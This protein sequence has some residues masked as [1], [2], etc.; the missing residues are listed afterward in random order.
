VKRL[1]IVAFFALVAIVFGTLFPYLPRVRNPNENTRTYATMAVVEEHTFRVDEEVKRYAWTNDLARVPQPDGSSHLFAVK[2]PGNTYLAIPVYWALRGLAPV[3]HL[4]AQPPTARSSPDER[5]RWFTTTT[6]VLR[7]L[8]V[9]IP[10][11]LFLVWLERWLRST[12]RDVVLRIAAVAGAGLGTNYLAYSLMFVSHTLCGA[13]AF[14]AFGLTVRSWLEHAGPRYRSART[15]LAIGF[16][17]GGAVMFEY[18][19][20]PAAFVLAVFAACVHRRP[21]QLLALAAGGSV[22]VAGMMLYQWKSFGNPLTPGH[23]FVESAVFRAQHEKGLYGIELP[24]LGVLKQMAFSRAFGFFG[25]S[26]FMW[27]GLLSIPFGVF[28]GV[29]HRRGKVKLRVVIAL[30]WLIVF[31]AFI[32]VSGNQ[33]WHGGWSIGPRYWTVG[34]PFFAFAAVYALE[35]IAS[36]WPSLRPAARAVAAGMALASVVQTGLVSITYNT[37]PESITRPLA[38]ATLPLLRDGYVPH[39]LAELVGFT[40]TRFFYFVAGCLLI[41][42]LIPLAVRAG[43]STRVTVA[44]GVS[45]LAIAGLALVPAFSKPEP[46]EADEA[47]GGVRFLVDTWDPLGR[48]AIRD[49]RAEVAADKKHAPCPR[50]E[51]AHMERLVGMF[52]EAARDEAGLDASKCGGAMATVDAFLMKHAYLSGPGAPR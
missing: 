22:H 40:G 39:H 16:C 45:A 35:N 9:Q 8:T 20:L 3:L 42:A 32:P 11:F 28:L 25:T 51:L 2:A 52:S 27:V 36:R 14:L 44:R 38:E 13:A 49:K 17:A 15:A 12:T 31:A 47:T 30:V 23:K 4:A 46:E 24:H 5:E 41:A 6:F 1:P 18:H 29:Q 43:D 48:D 19:A 7:F 33:N 26:P 50:V 21:L 34:P 10:C 37:L